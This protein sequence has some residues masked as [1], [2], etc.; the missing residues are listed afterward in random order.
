MMG[1]VHDP[2][3][4]AEAARLAGVHYQTAYRWV[5]SG[6]LPA[7]RVA[8]SYRVQRGDVEAL[9]RAREE[10]D[11]PPAP[12]PARLDRQA[13]S[14]HRALVAGDER[15][16]RATARRLVEDGASLVDVIERTI[17]PPLR[18]IGEDW[19]AGELDIWVEHR[20]SAIVDR[21]LGDLHP[22]PRGR[23][24][25]TA[26]V[27]S[28]S[29]DRHVLPTAMAAAA[30]REDRWLVHHL[31]ADMPADEVE[32]FCAAHPVDLAV[33]TV[34]TPDTADAAEELARRLRERGIPVLVGGPGRT[35]ADL[36]TD[37]RTATASHRRTAPPE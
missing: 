22:S 15:T 20:A 30:L 32:R 18:R 23:R 28:L 26:V 3:S 11:A 5:R 35:L 12:G 7:R 21:I 34:T 33:V 16:A 2:L 13:G 17:V 8:G 37:A 4:L 25:G 19:R 29:G 27:A 6:R 9:V 10:P 14:M 31:G 1:H 36:V 24:R